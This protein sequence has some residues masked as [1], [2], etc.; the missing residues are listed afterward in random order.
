MVSSIKISV[1]ITSCERPQYLPLALQSVLNQSRPPDEVI[2]VDDCSSFDVTN[3]LAE[4]S[5]DAYKLIELGEKSGANVARNTG[6]EHACG[7]VIAFLDDD[8]TWG[9]EL[10]AKHESRYVQSNVD[11]IVCGFRIMNSSKE[12]VNPAPFVTAQSLRKGNKFCG[13]SGVS[14]KRTALLNVKFDESLSNGQDW[15]LYIRF[16]QNNMHIANISLPLFYY[17]RYSPGGISEANKTVSIDNISRRLASTIKHRAFLGETYF[18]YRV[19]EQLL[20]YIPQKRNKLQWI[21]ES[22]KVSGI[23]ITVN[24]LFRKLFRKIANR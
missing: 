22:V 19:S 12:Y 13:A 6:V 17:R 16:V 24:V 20:A 7:D 9:D 10:L 11:A 2:I 21:L 1:V 4:F 18:K 8:D 14:A 3:V 15:D 5:S 23:V